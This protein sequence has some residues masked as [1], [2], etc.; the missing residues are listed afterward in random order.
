MYLSCLNWKHHFPPSHYKSLRPLLNHIDIIMAVLVTKWKANLKSKSIMTS[1]WKHEPKKSRGI[2]FTCNDN[3]GDSTSELLLVLFVYLLFKNSL[4]NQSNFRIEASTVIPMSLLCIKVFW[5]F[6]FLSF[7]LPLDAVHWRLT[8]LPLVAKINSVPLFPHTLH[9]L[10]L[11]TDAD[12]SRQHH[13]PKE[14]GG[15]GKESEGRGGEKRQS[16]VETET[17]VENHHHLP[18]AHNHSSRSITP[19]GG[20]SCRDAALLSWASGPH[21]STVRPRRLDAQTISFLLKKGLTEGKT[22]WNKSGPSLVHWQTTLLI[23]PAQRRLW[24]LR[25]AKPGER[26]WHWTLR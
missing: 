24:Y 15:G 9:P 21:N 2:V 16:Q 23:D 5:L 11:C 3:T 22:L 17:S 18:P 8:M 1:E 7:S 4:Q 20:H 25:R 10:C 14:G 12:I 6:F 13:H 26:S 19:A